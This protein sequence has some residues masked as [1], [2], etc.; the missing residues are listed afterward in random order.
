MTD[1][2]FVSGIEERDVNLG[3]PLALEVDR[4]QVWTRGEL[5]PDNAAAERLKMSTIATTDR[6]HFGIV[7][8]AHAERF[9][10][11]P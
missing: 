11:V 8:L 5:H 2:V 7:W 1:F 9:T 10:L 6:R 3:P 4:Q